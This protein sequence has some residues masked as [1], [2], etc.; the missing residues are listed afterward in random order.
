M[1]PKMA[2]NAVRNCS[3]NRPGFVLRIKR[4]LISVQ[5]GMGYHNPKSTIPHQTLPPSF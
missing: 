5:Y 4:I 2:K 1:A 3:M